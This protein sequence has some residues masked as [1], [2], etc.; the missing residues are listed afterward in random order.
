MAVQITGGFITISDNTIKISEIISIKPQSLVKFNQLTGKII[1]RDFAKIIINTNK[2][3]FKILYATDD[4]R[5]NELEIIN[6]SINEFTTTE[7]IMTNPN[8]INIQVTDSTNVN[9]VSQSND[10]VINQKI[11]EE[12]N[13]KISELFERLETIKDID[14][15][16]K[17]DIIECL[18]DIKSNVE[19]NK[20]T[21]KYSLKG[22]VDLTSKIASLSSLGIGIAQL[23]GA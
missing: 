11:K 21:P 23:L 10:V 8:S 5:D 9:I 22:L 13:S 14:M 19:S 2:E 12:V 1:A 16:L 20:K 3:V 4:E 6:K 15:E 7:K 17:N 18:T